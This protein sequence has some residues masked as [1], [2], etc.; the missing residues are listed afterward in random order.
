MTRRTLVERA[1]DQNNEHAWEEFVS[2]YGEFIRMVLRKM[3]IPIDDLDDLAQNILVLVWRSLG[4]MEIGKNN[5]KF[6]TW[7]T[8]VIRNAAINHI[9]EHRRKYQATSLDI[10]EESGSGSLLAADNPEIERLIEQE[11]KRHVVDLALA[12]IRKSF[13]GHAVEVLA[14]SLNGES[15]EDICQSLG[16]TAGSLYVLR[17]RI[18]SRFMLE[19]RNITKELEF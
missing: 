16:L 2:F 5:A 8:T 1:R 9:D 18:K 12:R 15:V 3:N 17:N 14:R 6:R 11:W 19:I 10:W 13:S 7:L 4:E